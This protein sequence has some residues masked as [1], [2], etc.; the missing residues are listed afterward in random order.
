MPVP[1]HLHLL[2]AC[3]HLPKACPAIPTPTQRLLPISKKEGWN[4]FRFMKLEESMVGE[5]SKPAVT[6]SNFGGNTLYDWK[7]KILMKILDFKR[8]GIGIIPKFCGIPS[9]FPNQGRRSFRMMTPRSLFGVTRLQATSLACYISFQLSQPS[10]NTIYTSKR[11]AN[12]HMS[13]SRSSIGS[14]SILHLNPR[15]TTTRYGD[16]RRHRVSAEPKCKLDSTQG[17]YIQMSDAPTV[18]PEKWTPT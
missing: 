1:P 18:E 9:G 10:A 16:P 8:S 7:N 6:C 17:K 13:N 15:W 4:V 3:P 11:K 2:N 12:G 5:D 14:I